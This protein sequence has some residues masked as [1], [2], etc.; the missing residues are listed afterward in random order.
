MVCYSC[1]TVYFITY[2]CACFHVH[3]YGY[4][5][6]WF[7]I[8]FLFI[9]LLTPDLNDNWRKW[10]D[11]SG[12]ISDDHHHH[13]W[14]ILW[15]CYAIWRQISWLTFAQG[16]TWC[17]TAPSHSLSQIC[18]MGTM[19]Y[20]GIHLK[21]ISKEMLKMYTLDMCSSGHWWIPQ[22][23]VDSHKIGQKCTHVMFPLV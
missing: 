20:C 11:L 17:L 15:P 6:V 13:R 3:V 4:V 8:Q 2:V 21:G 19:R 9:I 10:H 5:C 7:Y 14:R 12:Y 23:P 1:G 22:C 16:M 18:L